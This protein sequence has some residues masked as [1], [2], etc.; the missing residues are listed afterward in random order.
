MVPRVFPRVVL[1]VYTL[2]CV[3]RIG[4]P[5]KMLLFCGKEME[6][7][8]RTQ[9]Q[10]FNTVEGDIGNFTAVYETSVGDFITD[11]QLLDE[12]GKIIFGY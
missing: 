1:G 11:L 4:A 6:F 5:W 9:T 2:L 8:C 10:G 3:I 12:I 7:M